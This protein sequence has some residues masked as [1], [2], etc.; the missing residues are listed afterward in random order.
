MPQYFKLWYM[1]FWP[2]FLKLK[3]MIGQSTRLESDSQAA[4]KALQAPKTTSRF[5]QQ[6]Q[7]A[8]NDISARYVVG[9]FWVPGH[10]GVRVNEIADRL[11]RSGS[12]HR[13]IGSEPFLG[14]SRQNIRGKVKGWIGNQHLALWREPFGTPRQARESISGP[15]LAMEPDYCPLTGCNPGLLLVWSLDI[16][17]WEDTCV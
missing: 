8:L 15:N 17:P 7:Q 12:G 14:V 5:V 3:P 2:A 1:R 6:C 10:D 13:F 16:T 9:L 4:L 11:A